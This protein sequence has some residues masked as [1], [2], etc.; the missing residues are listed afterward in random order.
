MTS[1]SGGKDAARFFVLPCSLRFGKNKRTKLCLVDIKEAREPAAPKGPKAAIPPN[2]A[3]RVIAGAR[4]LSPALGCRMTSAKI[5]GREV[6][7]RE[8]LPQDLKIK[9]GTL[10]FAEAVKIGHFLASVVGQAHSRQMTPELRRSWWRDL[11]RN[12]SKQRDAPSWL[13]TMV[14]NLLVS[15]EAGYLEHCRDLKV[16]QIPKSQLDSTVTAR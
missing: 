16:A 1:H 2:Q 7:L 14:I 9:I 11:Q 4:H 10:D 8:L 6:F 13:W 12:R 3:E 15:H 5:A